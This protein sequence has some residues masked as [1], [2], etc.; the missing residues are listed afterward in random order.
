MR[1]ADRQLIDA[2]PLTGIRFSAR[3]RDPNAER[4]EFFCKQKL[5]F[6]TAVRGPRLGDRLQL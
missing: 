5:N 1:V 6:A 3:F 4:A 2:D